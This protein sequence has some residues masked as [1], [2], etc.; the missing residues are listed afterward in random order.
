MSRPKRTPAQIMADLIACA[1]TLQGETQQTLAKKVK[2]HPNTVCND[3]QDPE[4]IPQSRLWLYFTVL[5]VP[6]DDA[7]SAVA[8][9]FAQTAVK[10]ES[11]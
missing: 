2:V 10:R 7:L 6:V 5:G 8:V 3:F 1:M 11:R 4:R 9:S